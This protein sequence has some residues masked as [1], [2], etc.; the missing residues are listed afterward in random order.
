M[1]VVFGTHEYTATSN[2]P[3][4]LL[5]HHSEFFRAAYNEPFEVEAKN[6]ITLP[7]CNPRE[8]QIFVN[9][10]SLGILLR[11]FGSARERT[12]VFGF[13]LS[14]TDLSFTSSGMPPCAAYTGDIKPR[15]KIRR[16]CGL[17]KLSFVGVKQRK[18]PGCVN[19]LW[20]LCLRGGKLTVRRCRT[21]IGSHCLKSIR[22]FAPYCLVDLDKRA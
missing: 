9:W 16:F 6:R 22:T 12:M 20:T 7:E 3:I 10:L 14:A 15:R 21:R 1:E 2:L 13:G 4:T 5:S 17:A 18:V 19:S 8:F 11:H